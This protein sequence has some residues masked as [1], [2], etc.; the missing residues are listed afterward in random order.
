MPLPKTKKA[1]TKAETFD[2]LRHGKTFAKTASKYGKKRARKQMIAIALK[3][4]RKYGF[5]KPIRGEAARLHAAHR[6][7]PKRSSRARR[8]R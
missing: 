8:K 5:K 2:D 4:E 7:R 1:L 6:R 3:R